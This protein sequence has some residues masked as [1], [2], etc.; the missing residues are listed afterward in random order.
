MV[1]QLSNL[2]L[3]IMLT[4]RPQ[5]SHI[6]DQLGDVIVLPITAKETDVENYIHRILDKERNIKPNFRAQI[7]KKLTTDAKGMSV[8]NVGHN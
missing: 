8:A 5:L 3:K 1:R 4:T 2:S 7:V 6:H